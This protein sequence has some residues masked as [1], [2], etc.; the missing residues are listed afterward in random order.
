[1]HTYGW[2][3]FYKWPGNRSLV[4]LHTPHLHGPHQ[5]HHLGLCLHFIWQ[6]KHLWTFQARAQTSAVCELISALPL[7]LWICDLLPRRSQSQLSLLIRQSDAMSRRW[8]ALLC[9]ISTDS[10][11]S[12]IQPPGGAKKVLNPDATV[13][14]DNWAANPKES[15]AAFRLN[16]IVPEFGR[17]VGDVKPSSAVLLRASV[18]FGTRES[19]ACD[20]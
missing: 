4:F 7:S 18:M 16:Y 2:S 8:W 3:F 1:M 6:M 14:S 17:W 11:K 19:T 10:L 9:F 20:W 15:C 5:V 12:I 13:Q